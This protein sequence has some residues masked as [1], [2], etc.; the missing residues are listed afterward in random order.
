M[1]CSAVRSPILRNPSVRKLSNCN[2][3][4]MAIIQ[5]ALNKLFSRFVH[6]AKCY[7]K[8]CSVNLKFTP[9]K[10]LMRLVIIDKWKYN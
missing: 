2:S 7:V 4:F 9:K 3:S 5:S 6:L 10:C 8:P 1:A